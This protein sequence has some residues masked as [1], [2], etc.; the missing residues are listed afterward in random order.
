MFKQVNGAKW[1]ALGFFPPV[2]AYLLFRIYYFSDVLPNTYYAKSAFV[3]KV[4]LLKSAVLYLGKWSIEWV[5]VALL[6]FLILMNSDQSRAVL[7]IIISIPVI[8]TVFLGGG[9][10]MKGIRLM[11]PALI[12]TGYG[13]AMAMKS[14]FRRPSVLIV[15]LA[16]I[17]VSLQLF[18]ATVHWS[19]PLF[20]MTFGLKPRSFA[21]AHGEIVGRFLENNLPPGTLV[22]VNSAGAPPYFGRSL[23]FIDMLG[24]NDRA[25]A[26]RRINRITTWYQRK[27]GHFKGDGRYVLSRRPDVIM[28]GLTYGFL[29]GTK[30]NLFLSD[31]EIVNDPSFKEN[32]RPFKIEVPITDRQRNWYEV[33]QYLKEGRYFI[34]VWLRKASEKTNKLRNLGTQ[35]GIE[36][37]VD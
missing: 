33:R 37:A 16:V 24:L 31:Y 7:P 6:I 3:S 30:D 32:Y 29:T 1:Y 8:A 20:P 13:S 19:L 15:I 26:R 35:L 9:D 4:I 2:L 23:S 36:K 25:I 10:H 22:A 11:L 12:L 14:R 5:P 18:S 21:A 28:I 34:I 27:P 17:V